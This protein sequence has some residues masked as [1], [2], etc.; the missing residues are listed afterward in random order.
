ME[1]LAHAI[2]LGYRKPLLAEVACDVD[3]RVV[4]FPGLADDAHDGTLAGQAVVLAVGAGLVHEC[5][6]GGCAAHI[7]LI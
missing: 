5:N 2:D 4:L 6:L 1:V 7:L 3:E